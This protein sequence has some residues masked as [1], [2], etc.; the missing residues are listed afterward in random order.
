MG[1]AGGLGKIQPTNSRIQIGFMGL[2]GF[3]GVMDELRIYSR[4]FK[5]KEIEELFELE[6]GKPQSVSPIDSLATTLGAIR[7]SR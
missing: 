5:P 6:P 3:V 2:K 4:G 1:N 7:Q